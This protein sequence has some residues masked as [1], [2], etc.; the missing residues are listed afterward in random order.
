MAQTSSLHLF[1]SFVN[2]TLRKDIAHI[3]KDVFTHE[4][5]S[6]SEL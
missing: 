4:A 2:L 3:N 6:V 5:E 1:E